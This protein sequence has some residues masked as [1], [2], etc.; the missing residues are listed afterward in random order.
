MTRGVKIPEAKFAGLA[1]LSKDHLSLPVGKIGGIQSLL[2]MVGGRVA[3]ADGP[4]AQ[5][6]ERR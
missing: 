4:L 5:F 1:L 2:A 3:Y 6:E